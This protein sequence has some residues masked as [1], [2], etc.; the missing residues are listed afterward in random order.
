MLRIHTLFTQNCRQ[1][2]HVQNPAALAI[3]VRPFQIPGAT[4]WFRNDCRPS[5][6]RRRKVAQRSKVHFSNTH[7]DA[8]VNASV[9]Q[10]V[11]N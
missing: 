9:G 3:K 6:G 2:R 10:S 7:R 5:N 8:A 4:D 1:Q 11:V